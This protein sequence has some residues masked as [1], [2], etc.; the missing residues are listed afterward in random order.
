MCAWAL[1]QCLSLDACLCLPL[2]LCVCVFARARMCV[3]EV[4]CS[5][6]L[7]LYCCA[8]PLCCTSLRCLH[9]LPACAAAVLYLSALQSCMLQSCMHA[10]ILHATIMHACTRSALHVPR[11]TASNP[12][13][14]PTH[15]RPNAR[16]QVLRLMHPKLTK[17]LKLKVG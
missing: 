9:A 13:H 3:F 4:K 17:L 16:A 15:D 7:W 14:P 1:G 6:G 11:V 8:V 12:L 5:C 10:L 2:G